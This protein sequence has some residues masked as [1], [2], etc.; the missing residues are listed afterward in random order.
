VTG[1]DVNAIRARCEAATP[2]PWQNDRWEIQTSG[3]QWVAESCSLDLGDAQ[4]SANGAFIGHA[5]TDVPALLDAL[6]WANGEVDRL[7]IEADSLADECA[8]LQE[9]ADEGKAACG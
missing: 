8:R 4:S 9:I 6:V 5:R 2:G 1:L 3:C 7:T